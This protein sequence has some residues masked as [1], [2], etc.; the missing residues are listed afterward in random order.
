MSDYRSHVPYQYIRLQKL[1]YPFIKD[2][3]TPCY[4]NYVIHLQKLCYISDYR[5]HVIY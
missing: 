1:R 3:L 5:G 4:R 2:R